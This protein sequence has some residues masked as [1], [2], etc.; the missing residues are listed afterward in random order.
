[1]HIRS[2]QICNAKILYEVNDNVIAQYWEKEEMP[3]LRYCKK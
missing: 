3:V 2:I 1:M